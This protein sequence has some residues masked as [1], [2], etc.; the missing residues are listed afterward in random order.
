[1]ERTRGSWLIWAA[2]A[3]GLLLRGYHYARNP[4]VWH[5]EAALIVNVLRL[6]PE[7]VCGPLMF[8]N[9]TPPLFLLVEQAVVA[10]LGD[11]Q[12]ALRLPSFVAACLAVVLTALAAR[13]L[14]PPV[15][16]AVAVGLVAVSDRL[17]WHASEAK[18]YSADVFLAAA[19]IWAVVVTD[20]RPVWVRCLVA[21][22]VAPACIWTS[23]PACFVCGGVLAAWLPSAWR[24]DWKGRAAY[25]AFAAA[26]VISF[27]LLTLGPVKAQR[28][29][30]LDAC[31][32]AESGSLAD[33]NKPARVPLWAASNTFDI[34]R[35]SFQPYGWPLLV[36]AAVGGWVLLRKPGGWV[37]ACVTLLPML[38]V[39]VA[40]CLG[41]YPYTAARTTAFLTPGLAIT[42][43]IGLGQFWEWFGGNRVWRWVF[44]L[45]WV[46]VL[47]TP[48][49]W[50]AW[51]VAFP[52]P[53]AE[54]DKAAGDLLHRRAAGEPVYANHWEF[55]YYLRRLEPGAVTL[56]H[57]YVPEAEWDE[58]VKEHTETSPKSRVW[59]VHLEKELPPA[60][61]YRL[62]P[63]YQVKSAQQ[64]ESVVVWEVGPTDATDGR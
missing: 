47:L 17:L 59:V 28:T 60:T 35:Y 43:C 23:F 50:T 6:P 29:P 12:Y 16:A 14:L 7:A 63:G 27:A 31:W 21:A 52:W 39:F 56:V 15:R 33:W 26:V 51:T 40:A 9:A 37:A 5:D 13:R 19:A 64:F 57:G 61:L 62:P 44:L 36:P 11:G 10:V 18:P 55:D 1:M 2:V 24:S 3:L 41:K 54:C 58:W 4:A 32:T 53:R 46:P 45:V 34:V 8:E 22:A 48:V 49:V 38:L 20:R 30:K 25:L 42:A